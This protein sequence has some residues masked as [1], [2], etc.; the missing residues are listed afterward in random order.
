M[1]LGLIVPTVPDGSLNAI[2][3]LIG[4]VIMPHNLYLHSALVLS[5]KI[6]YRN[7]NEVNDGNYYNAIE[8]AISL[9]IS[10]FIN[11]FVIATFAVFI[12]EHPED[13]DKTNLTSAANVL[14]EN[15][16]PSAKYI[17]AIGLLAAG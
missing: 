7:R 11:L 16:G 15:I 9:G 17:W 1:G 3:G 4:A 13:E 10:F 6:N 8:S 5:R 2:L 14:K 12:I